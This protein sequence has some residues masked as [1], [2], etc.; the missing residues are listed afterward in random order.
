MGK[1]PLIC[2]KWRMHFF[3]IKCFIFSSRYIP[4]EVFVDTSTPHNLTQ[5]FCIHY[6]FFF[7]YSHHKYIYIYIYE[8]K[9]IP[10]NRLCSQ[11][12]IRWRRV[13]LICIVSEILRRGDVVGSEEKTKTYLIYITSSRMRDFAGKKISGFSIWKKNKTKAGIRAHLCPFPLWAMYTYTHT[14]I[15]MYTNTSYIYIYM[16]VRI[17]RAK[18][19][20]LKSSYS[21]LFSHISSRVVLHST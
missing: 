5:I 3:Q 14:F 16:S 7:L 19:E 2:E 15:R 6:I 1:K 9:K 8:Y 12:M 17:S 10:G 21:G 11:V 4:A 13:M 20:S 18:R